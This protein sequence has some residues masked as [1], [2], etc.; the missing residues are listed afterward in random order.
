MTIPSDKIRSDKIWQDTYKSVQHIYR[1]IGDIVS[2]FPDEE[3]NTASKLRSTANDSMMYVSVA[4]GNALPEVSSYDW[5][6][7][8]KY[9]FAMQSMYTFAA[10]QNFTTL[11]PEL[12]VKLDDI[13]A[14]IDSRI[15]D[16]Q[17]A[18][19]ASEKQELEPWLEKYRLWQKI[20]G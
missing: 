9:L 15:E 5:N 3:W 12:I 1:V 8:R 16:C 11:E 10:K 6:N 2:N 7:A 20:Q 18:K 14:Q 19:A 17:T 4:V 13:L